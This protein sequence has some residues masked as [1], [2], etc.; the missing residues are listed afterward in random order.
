MSLEKDWLL[1]EKYN[2]KPTRETEKDI[3]R[4]KNGEPIDYVIGF[5]SFLGCKVD[6]SEKPFIPEPETEFWLGKAIADIKNSGKEGVKVLDIFSG[7]GC[8]GLAVLSNIHCATVHFAEK[9]KKFL[10]QVEI[11]LKLNKIEKSRYKI[12]QSNVFS[13]INK[14]YDYIFAN[15]PYIATT[16]RSRIQKS[17]LRFEPK[18]A[19]FGGKDGLVYIKK[20]LNGAR[21][22]LKSDGKIYMEFD[23][24]QKRGL[25]KLLKQLGYNKGCEF[26]KDQFNKWRYLTI[27]N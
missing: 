23:Y 27:K 2:N 18:G 10:A 11:N 9:A 7:S 20:F 5:T 8:I 25:E 15:P 17:V 12:I 19:L 6:L 14:K 1:R 3:K 26:H 24:L 4:L 22:F 21:K 16:R 13:G